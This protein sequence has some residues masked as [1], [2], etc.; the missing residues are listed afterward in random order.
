M[1]SHMKVD[2][3]VNKRALQRL[4]DQFRQFRNVGGFLV[5]PHMALVLHGIDEVPD[6]RAGKPGLNVEGDNVFH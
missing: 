4:V 3:I 5:S 6:I 1:D 2:L